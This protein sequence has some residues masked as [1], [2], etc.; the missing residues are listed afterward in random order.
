MLCFLCFAE[1]PAQPESP[2]A[3]EPSAPM[4]SKT[5]APKKGKSLAG[6]DPL[7]VLSGP[8]PSPP[9]DGAVR[10]AALH[11]L[12]EGLSDAALLPALRERWLTGALRTC[13][14]TVDSAEQLAAAAKLTRRIVV[15]QVRFCAMC[16]S[17]C[18]TLLRLPRSADVRACSRRALQYVFEISAMALSYTGAL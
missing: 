17:L 1:P 13:V 4:K 15:A 8:C 11:A 18:F 10:A 3:P 2:P 9:F 14:A 6:D 7:P 5:R 12:A 16:S